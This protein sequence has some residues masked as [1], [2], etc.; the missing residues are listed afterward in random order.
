MGTAAG[1]EGHMRPKHHPHSITMF[2]AQPG[3]SAKT[4]SFTDTE[5]Y[6]LFCL[7]DSFLL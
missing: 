5:E 3:S 4:S 2:F 6:H 7:L 1:A